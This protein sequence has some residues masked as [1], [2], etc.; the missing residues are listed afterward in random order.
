MLAMQMKLAGGGEFKQP[1][2]PNNTGGFIGIPGFGGKYTLQVVGGA[3][4]PVQS[5]AATQFR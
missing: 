2:M 5:A 3:L 1:M 4:S